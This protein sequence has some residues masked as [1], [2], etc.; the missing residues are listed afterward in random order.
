[1]GEL[2]QLIQQGQSRDSREA[3]TREAE[4]QRNQG[5]QQNLLNQV[6]R[7]RTAQER[8]SSRL[9][10]LFTDQQV[11]IGT[12]RAALDERLGDLKELFGV[13]QTVAGDTQGRFN[14]SLT[15]LQYPDR[16]DFL[17]ELGSKMASATELASIEDIE[18]LWVTFQPARKRVSS[19][20]ARM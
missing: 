6:R 5:Q 7:D 13:L 8:E 3:R 1:M 16:G 14:S 15:N 12:A 2:L 17:V 19:I 20:D 4:F 18:T 11:E 9:E 10:L